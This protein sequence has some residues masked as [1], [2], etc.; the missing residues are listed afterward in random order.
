MSPE[1]IFDKV[2]T[3]QSDVWAYGILLWEIFSLGKWP[4]KA[5]KQKTIKKRKRE[6]AVNHVT[7][8][9]VPSSARSFPIP[10]H[11]HWRGVLPQ[12]EERNKDA[13]AWLQHFRDVRS[14][15]FKR[16]TFS[17]VTRMSLPPF[18]FVQTND[19]ICIC[20]YSYSIMLGCWEAEPSDRPTF[21]HLVET[22]G[23]LLQER[24]Q[25]V[26]AAGL[27]PNDATANKD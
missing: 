26:G 9:W 19:K 14:W 6:S 12:A 10:R 21:S 17:C 5:R 18:A 24:V 1:S 3:T 13:G 7:P 27:R 4:W 16:H 22:L 20:C 15:V 23:D 25:Q 11:Q 2:F 8:C